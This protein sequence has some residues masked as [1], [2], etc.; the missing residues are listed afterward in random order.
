MQ[1]RPS[2]ITSAQVPVEP[3]NIIVPPPDANNDIDVT[4]ALD[5]PVWG[6]ITGTL[7]NQT[8]LNT[9]LGTKQLVANLKTATGSS[10]TDYMSQK[11]TTDALTF[12]APIASPTFTGTVSGITKTMVGLG[13]ADNTSDANK[14]VSTAQ[15]T[16]LDLKQNALSGTF[17][18]GNFTDPGNGTASAAVGGTIGVLI[19]GSVTSMADT[20]VNQLQTFAVETGAATGVY[21]DVVVA[22]SGA[23]PGN[24]GGVVYSPFSLFVP[25]GRKWKH[26]ADGAAAI[27][28]LNAITL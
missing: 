3:R 10:D 25:A 17:N 19:F 23:S 22:G 13:N 16:A 15:Q 9:A 14:P 5:A 28:S 24:V 6:T 27:A 7:S 4:G 20:V 12:K 11:A 8:D 2:Y 1:R 18:L 21:T 26:T